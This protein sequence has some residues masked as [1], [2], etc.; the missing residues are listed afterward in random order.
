M[1]ERG[2][3]SR[4]EEKKRKNDGMKGGMEEWKKR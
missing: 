2:R 1:K 3:G 4:R